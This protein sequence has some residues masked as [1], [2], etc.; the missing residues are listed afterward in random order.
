MR[1]KYAE[2][3]EQREVEVCSAPFEFDG[4]RFTVSTTV[5]HN[6]TEEDVGIGWYEY[7]GH[8]ENDDRTWLTSHLE[9]AEFGPMEIFEGNEEMPIANPC[10]ELVKAAEE[11]AF[12]ESYEQA[13]D[14]AN[15]P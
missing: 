1:R 10:D 15:N 13:E 11:A 2:P 5:T 4:Q 9:D 3:T 6:L 8:M 7:W 12:H 14:K